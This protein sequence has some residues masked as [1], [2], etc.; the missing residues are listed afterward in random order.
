MVMVLVIYYGRAY[1]IYPEY[2]DLGSRF[3]E[4]EVPLQSY[5]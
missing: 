2:R 1:R 5:A 3:Y 4:K